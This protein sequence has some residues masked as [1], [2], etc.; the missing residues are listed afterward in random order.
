MKMDDCPFCGSDDIEPPDGAGYF[1]WAMCRKC[2][3]HGPK[4]RGPWD[5]VRLWNTAIRP[6]KSNRHD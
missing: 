2:Y 4:G 5:S 1:D 6:R 3:A